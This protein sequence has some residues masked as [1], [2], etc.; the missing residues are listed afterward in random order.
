M[1]FQPSPL[2]VS[3]SLTSQTSL[4]GVLQPSMDNTLKKG[5]NQIRTFAPIPMTYTELLP[6]SNPKFLGQN[7]LNIRNNLFPSHKG[8]SIN[9][10]EEE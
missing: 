8:T 5:N 9:I 2:Q 4:L 1:A 3:P 10:I 6:P 7:G